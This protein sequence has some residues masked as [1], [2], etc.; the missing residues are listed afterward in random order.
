[1]PLP[2]GTRYRVH[3]TP[4]GKK[5]RLAFRRGSS[6]VLEAKNLETG[7]THTM[8]EMHEDRTKRKRR[9]LRTR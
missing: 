8:R 7:A 4:S 9:P 1:M 6:E 5:I 3:T 2:A